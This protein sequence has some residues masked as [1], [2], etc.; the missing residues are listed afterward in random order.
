MGFDQV[1]LALLF[2]LLSFVSPCVLPMVPAYISL[3][4]GISVQQLR[5]DAEGGKVRR[6]LV[7]LHSL[8]FI[9]GFSDVF[10]LL[11]YVFKALGL[12]I[13]DFSMWLNLVGGLVVL[14][15]GL[16]MIGIL[17]IGFLNMSS[18]RHAQSGTHEPGGQLHHGILLRAGMVA[19]HRTIPRQ[20]HDHGDDPRF[21]LILGAALILFYALGMGI[22]FFL[23]GLATKALLGVLVG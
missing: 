23:T 10:I 20:H 9:L 18:H 17:K 13:P 5:G 16:N 7:M 3:M 15:F 14:T 6:G 1:F 4:S 22:P 11:F 12:I 8:M 2:G 21:R 19:V